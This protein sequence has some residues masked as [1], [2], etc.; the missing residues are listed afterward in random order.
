[1]HWG[2]DLPGYSGLQGLT[3]EACAKLCYRVPACKLW[4]WWGNACWLKNTNVQRTPYKGNRAG[5][6][7]CGSEVVEDGNTAKVE[8]TMTY[9]DI[10]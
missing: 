3:V 4:G 10:P 5:Q 2:G 9:H 8:K 7:I 6:K 1:M